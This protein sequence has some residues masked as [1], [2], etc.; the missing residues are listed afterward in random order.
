MYLC[1]LEASLLTI[2]NNNKAEKQK[3]LYFNIIVPPTPHS[4]G[5]LIPLSLSLS[6]THTLTHYTQSPSLCLHLTLSPLLHTHK[7]SLPFNLPLFLSFSSLPSPSL[8]LPFPPSRIFNNLWS[9][10]C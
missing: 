10:I 4:V 5:H 6:L 1:G 8:C 2:E 7:S 9:Q 3:S